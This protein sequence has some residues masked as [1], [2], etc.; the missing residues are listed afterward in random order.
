MNN[1]NNNEKIL[2][3]IAA[4]CEKELLNTVR[5]AL[6]QADNPNRIYFAICYQSDNLE[7]YE[8]LK[9]IPNCKIKYLKES[10]AKGLCYARYLCQQMIDDETY[11]YQI[12]AHMRFVK[13]WDSKMIEQLLSLNDPKASI[14]FYPPSCTEE[15]MKLPLNDSIFDQPA[16]G[17]SMYVSGFRKDS[18]PFL[19]LQST[20]L[21]AKNQERCRKNPFIS[22]GNFFSFS[23]IH[24][25]VI[26]DPNMFFYGDELPMAIRIFTHGWN[27][28]S[29]GESYIYHKYESKI[30]KQPVI[31]NAMKNEQER[32]KMLLGLNTLNQDQEG[33]GE[34]GFGTERSLKAFESFA[35]VDFQN[36]KIYM[37][38]EQG[39][40]DD[41]QLKNKMSYL[42]QKE[43]SMYYQQVNNLK[44]E[45]LMIDPL[46]EYL[47]CIQSCLEK[48]KEKDNISF[49]IGTISDRE[50]PKKE[51]NEYQI[52]TI[53]QYEQGQSY[54]KILADL[55]KNLSNSYV[56][57][58]DSSFRFLTGWDEYY[59]KII[60]TCGTDT[61]LT[62]WVWFDSEN[63]RGKTLQPYTNV[64]KV[65]DKFANYLPQ[66]KYDQDIH[67]EN[68][69]KP[70]QT[71]FIS[72]GFLFCNADILKTIKI[73]PNLEYQEQKV[74]Y[75]LRLWTHGIDIYYPSTSFLYKTKAEE[76][77]D[78]KKHHEEIICALQGINNYYSKK[79][80]EGYQYDIGKKRSLWSWYDFINFDYTTD[81]SFD[82]L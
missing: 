40:F 15:M 67:L 57:V 26:E 70:Y 72:D 21:L 48:A 25:E 8:E 4:Y 68:R 22:G 75:S 73:D 19:Y 24:K 9:K 63:N 32:F 71:A 28:Y 34:Y 47:E 27:N 81:K 79:L 14:S 6:I 1:N 59:C 62:S 38:A 78:S 53:Q 61:A 45:V 10:E 69:K 80:E 11:I 29:A 7:D 31:T 20:L 13:H 44:I 55:T 17:G 77:F 42:K 30:K 74:I 49:I 36:R 39:V 43:A 52:K 5:S 66:L 54:G 60:A 50:I 76:M 82:I 23:R 33:I 35:G 56:A 16:D 46:G 41:Q 65:F 18:D 64:I 58:V 3:E 37:S 51:K 12:D 2:I